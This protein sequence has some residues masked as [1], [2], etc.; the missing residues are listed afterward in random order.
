MSTSVGRRCSA[1]RG[2]ALIAVVWIIAALSLM[3]IGLV[4]VTRG[5]LKM[6]SQAT[7]LVVAA[8]RGDAAINLV[9]ADFMP[10][11]KAPDARL[12][13]LVEFDGQVIE[14]RLTPL[15]GLIDLNSAP[16]TLLADL[17][18]FAAGVE[19]VRALALARAI[20][21]WRDADDVA[22]S[23][24][25]ERETYVAAAARF[26]PRNG[27]FRAREDLLQVLG[28][29]FDLYAKLSPLVTVDG[30]GSGLV[31]PR[32]APFPVLVVLARGEVGLAEQVALALR[33]EKGAADT[34][35]LHAAHIGAG[36]N[37]RVQLDAHVPR[38]DSGAVVRRRIVDPAEPSP[39]GSPWRTFR[40]ETFFEPRIVASEP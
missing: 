19:S 18:Q 35:R 6:L 22:Q 26:L 36:A 5:E 12:E 37:G 20:V 33:R 15:S 7:D 38:A 1:Q 2:V 34:S 23:G 29:D 3:V 17:F 8:A 32:A 30:V 13:T 9:L 31:D 4:S 24:G 28:V 11:N 21:D 16:D 14:V 39:G 40:I 10:P 27:P 25:G